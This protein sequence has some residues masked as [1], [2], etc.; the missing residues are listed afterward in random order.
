MNPSE[1]R[2]RIEI[3]SRTLVDDGSLGKTETWAKFAVVY[4]AIWPRSAKEAFNSAQLVQ[5][6]THRIRIRYLSGLDS[7]MRIVFG[8]RTFEIIGITNPN[9]RGELLDILCRETT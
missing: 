1:L 6:T 2:H 4:A 3:Q 7:S 8:S 9:E 5:E